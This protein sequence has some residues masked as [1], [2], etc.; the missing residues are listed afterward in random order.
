MS[1]YVIFELEN[2]V[3]MEFSVYGKKYGMLAEGD[4]GKL[5]F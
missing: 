1:Y 4:E 5:I 3:W 2:G